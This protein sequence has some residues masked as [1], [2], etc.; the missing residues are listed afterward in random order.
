ME[1]NAAESATMNGLA[2]YERFFIIEGGR[3]KIAVNTF[4]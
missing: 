4:G 2:K 3:P 1:F